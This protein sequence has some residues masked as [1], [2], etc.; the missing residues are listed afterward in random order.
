MP[1]RQSSLMNHMNH[2]ALGGVV[3][4]DPR[5]DPFPVPPVPRPDPVPAPPNPSPMPI[6]DVPVP[7][8]LNRRPGGASSPG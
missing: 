7:Y 3:P 6:P 8:T 2:V 4:P 1:V 5:P